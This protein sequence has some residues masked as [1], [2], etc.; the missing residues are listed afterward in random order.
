MTNYGADSVN[1]LLWYQL[2]VTA[3][4]VPLPGMTPVNRGTSGAQ[5]LRPDTVGTTNLPWNP[6]HALI[7]VESGTV[8]VRCDG[9]APVPSEGLLYGAGTPLGA[10]IDYTSVLG[11]Y[12]AILRNFLVCRENAGTAAHLSISY[13]N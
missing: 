6:G 2:D 13:R 7:V 5:S 10:V 1:E 9:V 3:A 12:Q 4:A 8:R 11:D